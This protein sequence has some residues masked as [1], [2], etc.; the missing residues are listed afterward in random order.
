MALRDKRTGLLNDAIEMLREADRLHQHFFTFELGRTGPAWEP[1]V[2]IVE[3]SRALVISLA[4]P[5]VAADQVS[6]T[7]DGESLHVVAHRPLAAAAGE[8]IHRLEIPYGRF[9]RRIQLP[10]G[11]YE[12]L[13]RRLVDGCL[14]ITLRRLA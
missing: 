11:R 8:T 4:L 12:P 9:E 14:V 1:P 7:T 13:E 2:D 6:V 5:G 10:R 3:G